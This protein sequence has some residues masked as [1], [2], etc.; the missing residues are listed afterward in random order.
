MEEGS[1]FAPISPFLI[2]PLQ[3]SVTPPLRFP[4]RPPSPISHFRP[5]HHHCGM[6]NEYSKSNA[7]VAASRWPVQ[8]GPLLSDSWGRKNL[9][10]TLS[11]KPKGSHEP[12][13]WP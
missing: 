13:G 2:Q 4:S 5:R 9:Q 6:V 8:V 10:P 7:N 12:E 11:R 3:Y 1:R